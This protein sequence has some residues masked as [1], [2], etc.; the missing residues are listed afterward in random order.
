MSQTWTRFTAWMV[1]AWN[2]CGN[3]LQYNLSYGVR[4]H[5]ANLDGVYDTELDSPWT[6]TGGNYCYYKRLTVG[7]YSYSMYP[8]RDCTGVS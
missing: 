4:V 2:W 5:A 6:D 8:S 3:A 1:K 7:N